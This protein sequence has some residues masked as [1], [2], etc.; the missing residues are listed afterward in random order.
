M[1][2]KNDGFSVFGAGYPSLQVEAETARV[3]EAL[4]ASPRFAAAARGGEVWQL[5]EE[6]DKMRT[7]GTALQ[8]ELE[9]E[10][11]LE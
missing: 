6:R 9:V 5:T 10:A 4:Q 2:L 3:Q 8:K 11:T 1:C 7:K